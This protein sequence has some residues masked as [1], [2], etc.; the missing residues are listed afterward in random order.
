[1]KPE[2]TRIRV[3]LPGLPA[4]RSSWPHIG[5]DYTGRAEEI[6]SALGSA[7]P[8]IEFS[9]VVYYSVEE[10]RA[11]YEK[12]EKDNFDGFLIYLSSIWSTIPDFYIRT[13]KPVVISNQLYSGCGDFLRLTEIIDREK[14]PVPCVS[15]SD[16]Q[17][18]LRAVRLMDVMKKL[19]SSKILVFSD[20]PLESQW[21]ATPQKL[22]AIK[23]I[24]GLEV[25]MA[26]SRELKAAYAEID[27]A[28][29]ESMKNHWMAEAVAVMEP[30]SQTI[31][32]S[33]KLYAAMK[34]LLKQHDADALSIDCLNMFENG[35]DAYP[36]LAFFQLNNEGLTG[37]CEGDVNSTIAQL[38]F[39][40]IAGRPA[41]VSDPVIDEAAGQVI[42]A[43][44]VATAV[45]EPG[46][47]PC[48][49][50][51][52]SHAEDR[53]GASVQTL[54]PLGKTVTTIALSTQHHAMAVYTA[55]TV[56]NLNDEKACRTKLAATT[57]IQKLVKNYHMSIFGWHQVTCYGDYRKD[58]ISLA[59]LL[60]LRVVEQD[61]D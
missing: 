61:R 57:D 48:P 22:G 55:R 52:R 3:V 27:D 7:L 32:K 56:A 35:L 5:Y 30:D 44:C 45:P 43:H 51:I 41:Y 29:A 1:M 54:L 39:R 11:G 26:G 58:I 40:H 36:C 53:K 28:E 50:L 15:S 24:F 49:Y 13:G 60:G 17:D 59:R 6:N 47:I 42:Y 2:K 4:D 23:D 46:S 31:L 18:T 10:A 19:R 21:G 20:K 25:I 9:S 8:E 34:R 33:A 37:V 38:I 12:C 16:F 14:L